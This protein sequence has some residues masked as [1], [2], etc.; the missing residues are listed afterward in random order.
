M[1]L[2]ERNGSIMQP[3]FY[4]LLMGCHA[5]IRIG[6]GNAQRPCHVVVDKRPFTAH[7]QLADTAR[8][9]SAGRS[10]CLPQPRLS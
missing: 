5:P 10:A 2:P 6:F 8:W 4:F 7:E 1:D 3:G 9:P